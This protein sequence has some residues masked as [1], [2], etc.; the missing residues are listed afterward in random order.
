MSAATVMCV[1]RLSFASSS[2]GSLRILL[3]EK[4]Q[5][6]EITKLKISDP[7]VPFPAV[8]DINAATDKL[9]ML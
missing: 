6:Y 1:D 3:K 4:S 5:G 8:W 7:T 9:H 2:L